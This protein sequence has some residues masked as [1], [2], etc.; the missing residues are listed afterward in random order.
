MGNNVKQIS[1]N[2]QH[3]TLNIVDLSEGIYNLSIISSEGV[4]NQRLVVVH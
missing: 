1:F 4:I 3:L 2:T